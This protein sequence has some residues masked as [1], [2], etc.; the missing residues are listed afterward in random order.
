MKKILFFFVPLIFNSCQFRQPTLADQKEL[1]RKGAFPGGTPAWVATPRERGSGFADATAG[2]G[3]FR[4]SLSTRDNIAIPEDQGILDR[5]LSQIE[6]R[7]IKDEAALKNAETE[8]KQLKDSKSPLDRILSV[9]PKSEKEVTEA[10]QI[11][12][13]ASRIK[14]YETIVS[15]CP[16]SWDL[17]LWLAKDYEKN[18]Q[19]V[20]AGRSYEKVLV[21]N[22]ANDEARVSAEE[23]RKLLNA[24][25]PSKNNE[26]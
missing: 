16:D 11:L 5:K 13:L 14:K 18:H 10:L 2:D 25:K 6:A 22:P 9:C 24:K 8:K 21:I 4:R 20:Q 3:M 7:K 12:D 23:N 19:L 17:W 26:F 1:M 15:K